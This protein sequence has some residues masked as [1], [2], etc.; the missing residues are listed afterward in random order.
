M[1]KSGLRFSAFLVV[2]EKL[3]LPGS[4]LSSPFASLAMTSLA[5]PLC[6]DQTVAHS[7]AIALLHRKASYGFHFH[8]MLLFGVFVVSILGLRRYCIYKLGHQGS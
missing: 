2:M 4:C 1:F 6:H 5:R 8:Q 3:Y 7:A